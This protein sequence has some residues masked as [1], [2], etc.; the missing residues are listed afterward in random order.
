M[1][2][3]DVSLRM[4][5][6]RS[7]QAQEYSRIDSQPEPESSGYQPGSRVISLPA[8]PKIYGRRPITYENRRLMAGEEVLR[9]RKEVR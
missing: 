4:V 9:V 7:R 5:R 3:N 8:L 1:T 6:S 2:T